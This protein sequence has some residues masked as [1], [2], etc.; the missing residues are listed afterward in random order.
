MSKL[1]VGMVAGL[2]VAMAFSI[3]LAS[4]EPAGLDG[5][6]D[7]ACSALGCATTNSLP[8]GGPFDIICTWP[9]SIFCGL[10]WYMLK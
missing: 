1:N 7:D 2:I 3:P 5:A 6:V 8:L 10:A 9:S 4:A